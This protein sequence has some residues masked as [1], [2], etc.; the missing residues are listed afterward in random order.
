MVIVQTGHNHLET[1]LF[2]NSQQFLNT[3]Y[4]DLQ[5]TCF[6]FL[7][8]F[9][10]HNVQLHMRSGTHS[11]DDEHHLVAR[12]GLQ[13]TAK[14]VNHLS[15][16][17]IGRNQRFLATTTFTVLTHTY[18]HDTGRQIGNDCSILRM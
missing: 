13:L 9:A 4:N 11:I 16:C 8:G 6:Q 12:L 7:I 14:Q 17:I 15:S 3:T 10:E 5:A 1:G 18:L 2:L